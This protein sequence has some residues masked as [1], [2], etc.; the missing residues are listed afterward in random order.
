LSEEA[1]QVRTAVPVPRQNQ[2]GAGL[3]NEPV[4]RSQ[5]QQPAATAG[6]QPR[7]FNFEQT[8]KDFGFGKKGLEGVL[9]EE[10][11]VAFADWINDMF[12]KD[13]DVNHKLPLKKD[14]SDMYEKM[15]D[16]ILLCKIINL[17]A[18]DTIDERAINKGKEVFASVRH[19]DVITC[20]AIDQDGLFVMTGSADTTA[21]VWE[22]TA[23]ADGGCSARSVQVLCGHQDQLTSVSIAVCLDMAVTASKD[24]TVNI[25]SVKEGQYM[26]TI[27]P[28]AHDLSFTVELLNVSYQGHVIFTGHNQENH[29]LH[30][31]TLN[32]RHLA[33]AN[34]THRVTGLLSCHDYI[35]YGDENGDLSMRDLYTINLVTS[36]PLQLPIQTISLTQGNSHI[37][38]P[39]RDGKVIVIGLAG[40]PE[41]PPVPLGM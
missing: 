21:V 36:L 39:L 10:E 33:S 5:Q 30:V 11:Q 22:V 8:L 15:D 3:L 28:A 37:L 23:R 18:P 2:A 7:K 38:A 13:T 26:R 29:S 1:A 6:Q 17:A 4:F 20:V 32:G 41:S 27:R 40:I 16:G 34:L 12:L 19:T 9:V 24:G 35:L 25:H 14:G 31:F